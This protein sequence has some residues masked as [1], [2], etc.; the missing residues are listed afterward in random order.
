MGKARQRSCGAEIEFRHLVCADVQPLNAL[1][2]HVLSKSESQIA[3]APFFQQSRKNHPANAVSVSKRQC[4]CRKQSPPRTRE[5]QTRERDSC[6]AVRTKAH[7]ARHGDAPLTPGS[8]SF[9]GRSRPQSLH[10]LR[11]GVM[12]KLRTKTCEH[13]LLG[14]LEGRLHRA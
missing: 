13:I 7:V 14:V 2:I 9:C 6:I 8:L 10:E 12:H 3:F 4:G 11:H 5:I 1:Q